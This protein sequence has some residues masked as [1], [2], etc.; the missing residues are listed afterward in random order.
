LPRSGL[1]ISC[2]E[3]VGGL[4]SCP[5]RWVWGGSHMVLG[6]VVRKRWKSTKISSR[7]WDLGPNIPC[8]PL[9]PRQWIC[10]ISHNSTRQSFVVNFRLLPLPI[11]LSSA[12]CRFQ[13]LS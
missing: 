3:F 8:L 5:P 2:G 10:R 13:L 12:P 7:S 1:L 6:V 11:Q 9:S 4:A